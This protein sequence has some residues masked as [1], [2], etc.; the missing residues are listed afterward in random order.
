MTKPILAFIF[1]FAFL[2]RCCQGAN[3]LTLPPHEFSPTS[4]YH[5]FYEFSPPGFITI[6]IQFNKPHQ[7]FGLGLG[8]GMIGAD[9]WAFQIINGKLVANDYHGVGFQTPVLDT[10]S[11]GKNNLEILGTKVTATSSFVKFSRALNTGDKFDK[12]IKKGKTSFI[13]ATKPGSP[14][15]VYHGQPNCGS[16]TVNLV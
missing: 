5:V 8:T 6:A 11:G 4:Y 10:A 2:L 13:W 7:Y 9:I 12:V 14:T 16:L 15:L 3:D 1:L